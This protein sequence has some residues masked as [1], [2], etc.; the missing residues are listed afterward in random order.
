MSGLK[1]F[2]KTVIAQK[3]WLKDPLAIR[4]KWDEDEYQLIEHGCGKHMCF[5]ILWDDGNVIPH[6]PII[7]ALEITKK[8]LI[9]AGHRG[10]S[11]VVPLRYLADQLHFSG[12]LEAVETC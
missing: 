9:T 8:A 11:I 6:P 3:P 12:R 4:K 5:G 7:R 1:V 10:L 2:M